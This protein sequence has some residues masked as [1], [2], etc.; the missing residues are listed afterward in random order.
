MYDSTSL[1]ITY[2]RLAQ[3]S[4]ASQGGGLLSWPCRVRIAMSGEGLHALVIVWH[5]RAKG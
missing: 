3:P 5:A 2:H 4:F 1:R